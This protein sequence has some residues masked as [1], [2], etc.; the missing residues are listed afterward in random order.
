MQSLRNIV[1]RV[2]SILNLAVQS[3]GIMR[4]E[5]AADM[6]KQVKN[7]NSIEELRSIAEKHPALKKALLQSVQTPMDLMSSTLSR[8]SLKGEPVTVLPAASHDEIDE[9]WTNMSFVD[10]SMQRA[11]TQA[12][13]KNKQQLKA[14]CDHCCQ[15]RHYFFTI[16]KCGAAD[17]DICGPAVLPED[18]FSSLTFFPDPASCGQEARAGQLSASVLRCL[19][20]DNDGV[21]SGSGSTCQLQGDDHGWRHPPEV[22]DGAQ[23]CKLQ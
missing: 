22:R 4:S 18:V 6:E 19:G 7:A 3:I 16:K 5:M 20:P 13:I 14:L 9:M 8:L 1:E 11:E 23:G 12:S 10:A 17:Y 15:S 21:L 2:M